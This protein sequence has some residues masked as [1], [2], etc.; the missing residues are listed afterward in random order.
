M[1]APGQ[2]SRLVSPVYDPGLSLDSCLRLRVLLLGADVGELRVG[3]APETDPLDE[4]VLGTLAGNY[5][6]EWLELVI[7]I[8][9]VQ[10]PFQLF[11]E[12]LIG[13]SYLGDIAVDDVELLSRD[14]CEKVGRNKESEEL[15]MFIHCRLSR[16]TSLPRKFPHQNCL[17]LRVR[18]GVSSTP[19][20]YP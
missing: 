1:K 10:H 8:T 4:I 11:L 18:G 15:F 6:A 7:N 2:A 13:Q 5:G 17:L 19:P 9:Q 12:A 16:L 3:Q 20:R 14:K